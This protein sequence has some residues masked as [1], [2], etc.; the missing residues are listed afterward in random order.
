V[1]ERTLSSRYKIEKRIGAGGM[2]TVYAGMDTVLRR[3][4]AIKELRPQFAADEEFVKR[5]YTEAEHAAKLSHPNIVNIYDVG[6]EGDAYFIVMELV[7]GTTLAEMIE[8]DGPLPEP[9]V[10]DYATQICAGLAYAHRQGLLHRDI[11][12]ANI[13][14][15]KDDVVKLSDFGIARAVSTQTITV[16]QPG[17]VMGSVFYL[18]PEQAQGHDLAETSDLYSLGVVLFQM[19]TAKL[20]YTGESPITVALKHVSNPI[21]TMDDGE[22]EISPALSAIVYKLLQKDPAARFQSATEVASALREAR[23]HPLVTAPFEVPV[24]AGMRETTGFRTIPNPKPRP[25]RYPD[26]TRVAP[27]D[28][29]EVRP[30]QR[31]PIAIIAFALVAAFIAGYLLFS[32][33][34]FFGPASPVVVEDYVGRSV[35]DAEKALVSAGLAYNVVPTPSETVAKDHVI[36]Q[37]PKP[38]ATAMPHSVVELFVSSGLP[39]VGLIDL[40][41]YSSDDAE[42]YLRNAKLIPKTTLRYDAKA[43]KGAVLSQSPAPQTQLP[44]RSVVSLVVSNGQKPVA[45]PDLIDLIIGDAQSAVQ[46]RGLQ[47]DIGERV[48]SDNIPLDVV[49]GQNPPAGSHVDPG[50]KVTVTVSAGAPMVNVPDIGGQTIG[51]AMAAIQGNGLTARVTYDVDQSVPPGTVLQQDPAASSQAHKGS[52]VTLVVAV[53][54]VVPDVTNMPLDQART[55]LQNAGYTVGAIYYGEGGQPGNVVRTDP[56]PNSS[57]RPGGAVSLHVAGQAQ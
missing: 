33:G 6:R 48:T 37:V 51:D 44:I 29:D 20:P 34:G 35:D 3:R 55:L 52:P 27:R 16:T 36:R 43:P 21:P 19:L 53:P 31:F 2:A 15:T 49:V 30:S 22:N 4:V 10:I 11:K 47:L 24:F 1:T 5:F 18:S 28:D 42:R 25:T 13:L 14:I 9:V 57:L 23:E 26:R 12:P 40:R 46:K 17:L 45:V 32:H 39:V 54:G 7:D 56:E 38:D 50:S 41:Q 8:H